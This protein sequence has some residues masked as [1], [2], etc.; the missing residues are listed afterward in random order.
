MERTSQL[1]R[2]GRDDYRNASRSHPVQ[3]RVRRVY[4]RDVGVEAG[5]AI[6]PGNA[7]RYRRRRETGNRPEVDRT[8]GLGPKWT[9]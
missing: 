7:P 8:P 4:R 9:P 3:S 1:S 2:S 5:A 6:S